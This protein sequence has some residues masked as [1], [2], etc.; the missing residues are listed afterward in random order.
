MLRDTKFDDIDFP[1]TGPYVYKDGAQRPLIAT[2]SEPPRLPDGRQVRISLSRWWSTGRHLPVE[3]SLDEVDDFHTLTIPLR[4]TRMEFAIGRRLAFRGH[5]Q[6]GMIFL[7]GPKTERWSGVFLEDFD[8]L[9]CYI[10]QSLMAECYEC[11]HGRAPSSEIALLETGDAD[12]N[13]LAHLSRARCTF[14]SYGNIYGPCF[15]DSLGLLI[16]SRL[17]SLYNSQTPTRID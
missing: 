9:R 5:R 16:A 10:P 7:T 11:A 1:L 6:P 12:D 4:P 3:V 13:L 8:H 15:I 14:E 17:L 2:E